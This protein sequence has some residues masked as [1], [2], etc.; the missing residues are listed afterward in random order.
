L[1]I[2]NF[3]RKWPSK[4]HQRSFKIDG[5]GQKNGRFQILGIFYI[6]K[7]FSINAFFGKTDFFGKN[8]A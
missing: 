1:K 2:V 3:G 7:Y 8:D 4:G 5:F 6:L